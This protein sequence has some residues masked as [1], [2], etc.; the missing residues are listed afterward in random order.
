MLQSLQNSYGPD[1]MKYA[2]MLKD[3]NYAQK[4]CQ[5]DVYLPTEETIDIQSESLS[6]CK[7]VHLLG[8]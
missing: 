1:V 3:T 6:T 8:G 4:L 7:R 2:C 5:H